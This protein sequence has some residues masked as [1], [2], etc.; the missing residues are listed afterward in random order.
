MTWHLNKVP[1]LSFPFLEICKI[2]MSQ[3]YVQRAWFY[4]P[5]LCIRRHYIQLS[6][7]CYCKLIWLISLCSSYVCFSA[8]CLLFVPSVLKSFK[9]T[10]G[11]IGLTLFWKKKKPCSKSSFYSN[12]IKIFVKKIFRHKPK[13]HSY[14]GR[15]S[16]ERTFGLYDLVQSL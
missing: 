1:F 15:R 8:F 10:L 4:C 12:N 11:C 6:C 3:E 9:L 2:L 16:I 14:S 5:L 7:S 13:M